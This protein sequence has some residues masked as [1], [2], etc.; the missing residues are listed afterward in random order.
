MVDI[1]ERSGWMLK[2]RLLVDEFLEE[3]KKD[4]NV[5]QEWL[6]MMATIHD[7]ASGKLLPQT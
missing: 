4:K 5:R 6:E 7:A 2:L 3:V 1:V